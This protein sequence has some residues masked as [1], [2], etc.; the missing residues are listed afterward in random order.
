MLRT[1][2]VCYAEDLLLLFDFCIHPACFDCGHFSRRDHHPAFRH[3]GSYYGGLDG[4]YTGTR[5]I[6]MPR[7]VQ[8]LMTW[9]LASMPGRQALMFR[10]LAIHLLSMKA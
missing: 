7:K 5:L 10:A 9:A 8:L 1:L 3:D 2:E 4:R 6:P